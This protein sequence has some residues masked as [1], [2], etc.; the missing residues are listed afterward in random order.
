MYKKIILH[1]HIFIPKEEID[2]ISSLKRAYTAQSKYDS[3]QQVILFKDTGN[4][5]GIP[6]HAIR[7]SKSMAEE[8][9]DKRELGEPIQFNTKVKLWDYQ[10]DILTEFTSIINKGGTG[11]FLEAPPGSGKTIMGMD[12]ISKLGRKALVVVPKS[13]LLK[14]WV[15]RFTEHS[16]LKESDIGIAQAGKCDF[17]AKKVVIGLVHT[18]VKDRWG[19]DFRNCFG[20][21]LFDECD[22]AVCPVTFSSTASMFPAKYR[23]GMTASRTRG[24]GLHI[25]FDQHINQ[26]SLSCKTGNVMQPKVIMHK[27]GGDSGTIP[28]YLQSMNRRGVMIS[29]LAMNPV[30]N[31][32]IADYAYQSFKAGRPT[33]IVSDRK[34]Q[35][36][37]LH[38]FLTK[39]MRVPES[40]IGYYVR[41]LDSK[42]LSEKEKA[43]T[44]KEC[45][46]ILGTYGM[47]KRGTDI[48]R[49]STLILATPQSDLRQTSGRIERFMEGKRDPVIIDI[50][51]S[52]YPECKNSSRARLKFYR[53]RG[54]EIKAVN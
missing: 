12:M 8:I 44:A 22:S 42:N 53:D 30:R 6:R 38:H 15:A 39:V 3:K 13:D 32:L 29:N 25:V 1:S 50:V 34:D 23:I 33:L 10:E 52:S 7:L 54:L 45:D 9:I 35:L 28:H 36:K 2:D 26:F 37:Q 47:I 31:K 11:I 21:I 18:I 20:T 41:T 16:D 17:L 46:I 14:Q 4:Y 48:K 5:I 43:K 27:F 24:D 19:S 49:L 51:D 40:K